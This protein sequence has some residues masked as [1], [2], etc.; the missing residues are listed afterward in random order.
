MNAP[1]NSVRFF[2]CLFLAFVVRCADSAPQQ[3]RKI[4][5]IGIDGVRPDAMALRPMLF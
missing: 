5:F 2:A 3:Q 1:C 4:L